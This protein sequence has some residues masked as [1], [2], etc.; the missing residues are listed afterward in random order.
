[1]LGEPVL[2][3]AIAADGTIFASGGRG[4]ARIFRISPDGTTIDPAWATYPSYDWPSLTI[5][6]DGS[7]Y[8]NGYAGLWSFDADSPATLVS[9]ADV[10]WWAI[11]FRGGEASTSRTA[12]ARLSGSATDDGLPNPPG[13][14]TFQWSTAPGISL[15][16]ANLASTTATFSQP[17]TYTLT[18]TASDSELTGS[19]DM[20]VTV[21]G[22]N[23]APV[24]NAGP[25]ATVS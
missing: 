18:L 25:D 20:P 4:G 24:V 6:S 13:Q 1:A 7:L 21:A 9:P 12:V 15:A 16:N 11:D 2:A 3:L 17:G 10:L 19:A 22:V 14:L 5:G 8:A 23:Q